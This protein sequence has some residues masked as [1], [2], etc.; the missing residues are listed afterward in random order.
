M[1]F[2]GLALVVANYLSIF[3]NGSGAPAAIWGRR[4]GLSAIGLIVIC[5]VAFKINRPYAWEGMIE[6]LVLRPSKPTHLPQLQGLN[7]SPGT[8]DRL[9]NTVSLIQTHSTKDD[10][11]LVFPHLP[12]FYLLADRQPCAFSYVHFWDVCP[13]FVARADAARILTP[14]HEPQVIVVGLYTE[15]EIRTLERNFRAGQPSGQRDLI[16]AIDTLTRS[17]RYEL[18]GTFPGDNCLTLQV[19]ARKGR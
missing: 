2:P 16:A 7:L 12:I 17:G 19:W 1:V 13:D 8:V 10:E 18:L 3:Q 5:A 4:L 14:E 15:E 9:E 11:I 6:P